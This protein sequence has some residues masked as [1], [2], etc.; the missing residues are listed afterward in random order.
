MHILNTPIFFTH[1]LI[2]VTAVCVFTILMWQAWRSRLALKPIP[3]QKQHG[4][5]QHTT[6]TP[7]PIHY[8]TTINTRSA[9][10]DSMNDGVIVLDSHNHIID[11][12]LAAR[13]IIQR[14]T[15]HLV[16]KPLH[17]I[18]PT[19]AQQLPSVKSKP[20][21]IALGNKNTKR[22]YEVS[23]TPFHNGPKEPHGHLLVLRD[24]TERKK[25]ENLR[26]D[27]TRTMVHDLRDPI[28]N[29][30]FALEMLKSALADGGS[31]DAQQLLDLTFSST[32]KTLQLVDKI[33]EI[34]RLESGELPL[35]LTS[36]SLSELVE[37]VMAAQLPRAMN[38]QLMLI[39]NVPASLPDVWADADLL[40]RVLKNLLDNSIK[41][42]PAG[43]TI[44]ATAETAN[45][46]LFVTLADTGDGIP[47]NLR[48]RI[49]EQFVT[50][51][52]HASGS[53]LGL[54]FCKM[55]LTVHGQDIWLDHDYDMGASFTFS[56][57]AA[58]ESD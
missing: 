4:R 54:T 47:V 5:F 24:V 20:M 57:S 3:V 34:G 46:S 12:N 31:L 10:I 42:T 32:A 39:N 49:F 18:L 27:M 45:G 52:H 8:N 51:P 14:S 23:M 56:L 22:F 43:G 53:G 30:L 15:P 16:G 40:E 35:S 48:T 11:I 38:K 55:A 19:L 25:L 13:R 9:V 33:L 44:R 36:I 17:S 29:S 41:Y 21:D 37:N 58:P 1:A 26:E 6:P 50:G 7:Q 2:A 28:S